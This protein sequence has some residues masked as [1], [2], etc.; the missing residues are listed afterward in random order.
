MK[1][2]T[3]FLVVFLAISRFSYAQWTQADPNTSFMYA[4]NVGIGTS[5][6]LAKL[7]VY[8]SSLL[9]SNPQN[10]TL[11]TSTIGRAGNMFQNNLWLVR[12]TAGNDWLTSR[13]HDGIS[14]DNSFIT[15]QSDTRTWWERDPY[16]NIQSWGTSATAYLTIK[17]GNVGIGT[18]TPGARLEIAGTASS[19]N[20]FLDN[21][22]FSANRNPLTGSVVD[23]TKGSAVIV[24]SPNI[25][26][27]NMQF[28]TSS[29]T[30]GAVAE[31]M[32][33]TESGNVGIGIT[34]PQNKLD[35]NGTIHSKSVLI[36]LNG[37]GDYVFK[38][39]YHLRPLNEV[40]DYIDKNQHLPEIPSEQEMAKK[41]LNVS[42]M[43]ILLMKKVEELTLYLIEIK[44]EMKELQKENQRLKKS[45]SN[46]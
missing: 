6:P 2:L 16:N 25:N 29:A 34:N 31:R 40:K 12:N 5:N 36:D 32:R 8:Q 15:P 46:K 42:E 30:G 18:T 35:V 19:P 4:G 27:G 1:K 22:Q 33:I 45:K 41:G 13:L 39:G 23:A 20:L 43:N 11:L 14:I 24:L 26:G 10:A 17:Q 7:A 28:H 38:K 9:G 44:D 3:L 21:S 37:W